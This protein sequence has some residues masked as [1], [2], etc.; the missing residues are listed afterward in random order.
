MAKNKTQ[1][2]GSALLDIAMYGQVRS[3]IGRDPVRK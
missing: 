3:A 2:I 1:G